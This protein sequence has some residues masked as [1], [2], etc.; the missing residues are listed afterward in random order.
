MRNIKLLIEYDGTNYIGWQSQPSYQGKNIQGIIEAGIRKMV[1]HEVRLN[2]A[3]RTDAGVHARGQVANFFTESLI[4]AE[5]FPWAL[6]GILPYDIVVKAACDVPED[7]HARYHATEKTYRY[8][9]R[10]AALPDAFDWKYGYHFPYPL[11]ISE[12]EQAARFF[13][14]THDYRSFCAKGSPVKKFV[15]TVTR[16]ELIHDGDYLYFDVTAKGF[17]YHMVRI[18]VGTLVEIGRGRWQAED[19]KRILAKKERKY[20]GPTALAHGLY[21]QEVKY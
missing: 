13:L 19:I 1:H 8:V 21:L 17:L 2:A 20:A 14:G 12:M 6:K 11:N 3:G 16:A 5:R 15:R 10:R 18:M 4:P 7:F 9:I